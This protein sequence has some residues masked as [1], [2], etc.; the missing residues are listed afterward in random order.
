MGNFVANIVSG[1]ANVVAD[2]VGGAV[3]T[4]VNNPLLAVAAIATGGALGAFGAVAEGAAGAGIGMAGGTSSLV[5]DF[6]AGSGAFGATAAAET[7]GAGMG[8]GAGWASGAS[9]VGDAMA[10]A[11]TAASTGALASGG[12]S[13]WSSLANNA[14]TIAKGVNSA[15]QVIGGI[16]NVLNPGQ[17]PTAATNQA[18]PN[19]PYQ[20]GYAAKLNN[21]VSNPSMVNQTPGYQFGMQQGQEGLNRTMA[22]TG[23]TQSGGQQVALSQFGQNYAGN[24]WHQQIA[25]LQNLSTGGAVAGQQAG[26]SAAN[27]QT[28]NTTSGINN[29]TSGLQGLFGPTGAMSFWG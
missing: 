1:A 18:N 15:S 16:S 22:A 5:G 29:I 21:L 24:Q 27:T 8:I 23:Q 17:S 6:M 10:G 2:V 14:G 19:A 13:L 26:A 25:D 4:V 9:L 28:T 7:A 3:E 20:A 12:S 11:G